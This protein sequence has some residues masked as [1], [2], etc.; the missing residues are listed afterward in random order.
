M[1]GRFFDSFGKSK[2]AELELP[3]EI[4]DIMNEALPPSFSYIRTA[5]GNYHAEPNIRALD[6]L[7]ISTQLDPQRDEDLCQKL[8]RIPQ[9]KWG[10]YLY[11]IQRRVP[12]QNAQIGDNDKL[13]P[14]ETLSSNP[15]SDVKAELV[16]CWMYPQEFPDPISAQF[17]CL[18]GDMIEIS[19]QQQAYDSL[20]EIKF[21]NVNFPAMRI[22]VYI[23]N[24]LTEDFAQNAETSSD[25]PIKVTYSVVPQNAICVRDAIRSIKLF[26]G[27]MEG[28]AKV[29]GKQ[30]KPRKVDNKTEAK[31]IDET[32]A[33]WKTISEIEDRLKVHFVPSA[34]FPSEDERLM[35]ELQTCLIEGKSIIWRHPFEYF[36]FGGLKMARSGTSFE[37][38]VFS[39]SLCN[40]FLEGPIQASLLGAEF[41]L[42]S[43]TIMRDFVITNIEWDDETKKSGKAYITDAPEKT[44][45][46]ERLYMTDEDAMKYEKIDDDVPSEKK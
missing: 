40:V 7:I 23:F 44:W 16:D 19:F 20:C 13:I 33:F 5:D 35:V 18:D 27:L 41:V 11:R 34:G 8:Q 43:R 17:D 15:L 30:I 26:R 37:K 10:E 28:T 9:D 25:N 3:K 22:D 12:I 39:K 45:T 42:Y 1:F 46:L 21:S 6:G 4:V 29:N 2:D 36:H 24:P 32:E 31:K 14:I 38:D